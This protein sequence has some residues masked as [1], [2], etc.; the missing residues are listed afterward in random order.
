MQVYGVCLP[1]KVKM[2]MQAD[3]SIAAV[4]CK[5]LRNRNLFRSEACENE[6]L[7]L[8]CLSGSLTLRSQVVHI[9]RCTVALTSKRLQNV[10]PVCL[11]RAMAPTTTEA[12]APIG[13]I[14]SIEDEIRGKPADLRLGIRQ[15]RARPL[16]DEL[17]RWMEGSLR[18]LST[19]SETAGAIRYALVQFLK[20]LRS[21]ASSIRYT[22]HSILRW[23]RSYPQFPG[24]GAPA[25]A[26]GPLFASGLLRKLPIAIYCLG[27]QN[28]YSP[29]DS[30]LNKWFTESRHGE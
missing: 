21:L 26:H 4:C 30:M 10:G 7:V 19:K 8:N 11:D 28:S 16:L 29:Y 1:C 5:D 22:I 20:P 23:Q 9:H 3:C 6:S 17:R 2:R 18:S 12:L 13:A 15:S 27:K 24:T 25:D 14:Y